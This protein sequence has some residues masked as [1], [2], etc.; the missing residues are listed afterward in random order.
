MT[1][2]YR[3]SQLFELLEANAHD[4]EHGGYIEFLNQNWSPVSDDD[5]NYLGRG[6]PH[7]KLM[8]THLHLLEAMTTLYRAAPS[9]LVRERLVELI[10]IESNEVVRKDVVACTDKYRRDWTPILDPP[11]DRVSYGHDIENVW[12]IADACD[13]AAI[14]PVEHLQLYK[15]LRP[16]TLRAGA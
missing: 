13:A 7:A 14:D 16:D 3:Q 5:E 2:L 10:G 4:K 15:D 9:P 11:Y 12:L 8:N 1:D 6:L